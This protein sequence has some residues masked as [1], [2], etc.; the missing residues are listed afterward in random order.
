MRPSLPYTMQA[1]L[2]GC[3][4]LHATQA[5]M[6]AN[7]LCCCAGC[8]VTAEDWVG[9]SEEW[10]LHQVPCGWPVMVENALDPSH[11]P[12]LHE[13][14][15]DS[16]KGAAPMTMSRVNDGIWPP[17]AASGFQL[18]HG[19][20]TQEQQEE[21]MRAERDFVPPCTIRCASLWQHG[22]HC[23]LGEM[24]T[25]LS[26]LSRWGQPTLSWQG[27]WLASIGPPCPVMPAWRSLF[28]CCSANSTGFF[29]RYSQVACCPFSLPAAQAVALQVELQLPG[30]AKVG[31]HLVPGPCGA[32]RHKGYRKVRFPGTWPVQLATGKAVPIGPVLL[33]AAGPAACLRSWPA[34]PGGSSINVTCV[35]HHPCRIENK[36]SI[37]ASCC[38]GW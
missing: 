30:W 16:R 9:G 32:R 35:R 3:C 11:A 23:M 28:A 12:F 38:Q 1:P 37:F 26:W 7:P 15:L 25:V 4:R 2:P 33:D 13:G 8:Q 14:L 34:G 18:R 21:G 27:H 20:Y 10:S 22:W 17:Q 24:L 31:Q 19:G 36:V 29:S 6:L 5:S